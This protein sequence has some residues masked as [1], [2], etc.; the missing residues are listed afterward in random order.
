MDRK[1]KAR[2]LVNQLPLA[3]LQA[4]FRMEGFL[5]QQQGTRGSHCQKSLGTF[6]SKFMSTRLVRQILSSS[7][8]N[9]GK[10]HEKE[11][12]FP[13]ESQI[14]N[15]LISLHT[16]SNAGAPKVC[17]KMKLRSSKGGKCM[18]SAV[19]ILLCCGVC[20]VCDAGEPCRD[21]TSTRDYPEHPK[22]YP[23]ACKI[24]NGKI[25]LITSLFTLYVHCCNWW[26]F[27]R[28]RNS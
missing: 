4:W 7:S 25:S 21:P 6:F 23:G 18:T 3:Q 1:C 27:I 11:R 20:F 17:F 26:V 16:A 28:G 22:E 5:W 12:L 15:Y 2:R 19:F 9:G 14:L 24:D 10:P 8:V 13:K